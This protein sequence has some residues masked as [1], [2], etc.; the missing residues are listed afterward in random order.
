MEAAIAKELD[1][2]VRRGGHHGRERMLQTLEYGRRPRDEVDPALPPPHGGGNHER[3]R[4]RGG[5]RAAAAAAAAP[6]AA[7]TYAL[8]GTREGVGR[9]E[10]Y[11][12]V[13]MIVFIIEY[14]AAPDGIGMSQKRRTASVVVLLVVVVVRRSSIFVLM[15]VVVS[16]TILIL[17]VVILVVLEVIA[18]SLRTARRRAEDGHEG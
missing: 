3:K 10:G 14:L 6:G 4:D 15:V 5:V 11:L 12:R 1:V 16:M 7:A 9:R 2:I 18:P 13:V 17:V 8:E